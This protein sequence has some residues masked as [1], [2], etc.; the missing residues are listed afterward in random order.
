LVAKQHLDQHC[1]RLSAGYAQ[2]AKE[3]RALAEAHRDIAKQSG[4]E[5]K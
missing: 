2:A 3:N 4:N 5:G 1:N